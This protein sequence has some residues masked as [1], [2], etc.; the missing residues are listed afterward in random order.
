[1]HFLNES[2]VL[3]VPDGRR[4]FVIERSGE[5]IGFV[6]LAPIPLRSGWLTELFVRGSRAPNGSV[7]LGLHEAVRIVA[8]EG[9]RLLTM[10]MVPLSQRV[11]QTDEPIWF[12]LLSTWARAHGRRFYNFDGLD[13]FKAKFAP[14]Y[15]EPIFA[16][17]N[18]PTFTFRT[19]MAVVGA[20]TRVHP[21]LALANGIGKAVAQEARWLVQLA[22]P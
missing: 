22:K 9:A 5:P 6:V 16:V 8:A 21:V 19:F 20:F 13:F 18:E 11:E 4:F 15:W 3:D 14:D 2:D 12:R 7:E 1:M 17:S 10:G